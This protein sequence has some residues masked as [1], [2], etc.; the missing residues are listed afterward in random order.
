MTATA[1]TRPRSLLA[2]IAPADAPTVSA[3]PLEHTTVD[4]H[5]LGV[6]ASVAVTQRFAN[7]FERATEIV[8]R[9]PMPH[10]GVV[11][12]FELTIGERVVR[13]AVAETQQA[14]QRYEAARL[15]GVHGAAWRALAGAPNP[16]G[17]QEYYVLATLV[18]PPLGA[19]P[20]EPPPREYVFVMDRSGSMSVEPMAQAR[21]A[22]RA[23]LRTL[24]RD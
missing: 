11:G 1:P 10:E 12:G 16:D 9:F 13:G 22:L 17:T 19:T 8:Y 2:E 20:P 6:L 7:P 15:T 14:R 18:P 21:N 24:R 23:A 4:A 5:V 3:L